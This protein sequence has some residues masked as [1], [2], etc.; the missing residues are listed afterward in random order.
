[1]KILGKVIHG[2]KLYQLDGPTSDTD[3]KSIFLPDAKDCLL[4]RATKNENIKIK[5]ENSEYEGFCLQSFLTLAARAEDV[6]IT[7]LHASDDKILEDS[8]IYKYLRENRAMFYTK[9]MVGSLGFAKNMALKYGYRADRMLAVEKVQ[10]VLSKSIEKGFAR[11]WQIWD[12]LP[13]GEYIYRGD[14]S[15]NNNKDNRYYEVAGKKLQATVDVQYAFDIIDKL[16]NSYGDRV[17]IA[18]SMGGNDLKAL[19]H[20]FRVGYQLKRIYTEGDL[21][22]PLK[23]T[24][25]IKDVKYGKLNYVDDKLDEKLNDLITEVENLAKN[26]IYG[27]NVDQKWLDSIVLNAYG[28]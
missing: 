6:A 17:K 11:L 10:S 23:E 4:M 7:M 15:R 27:D 1:M 24:D 2:S 9:K 5:E 28:Y 22:Y 25:F 8:E 12:D 19:S 13:D 21:F 26:S 20:S 3:Y 16:Y 18:K 14:D